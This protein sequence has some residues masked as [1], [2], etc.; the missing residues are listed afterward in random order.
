MS[1]SDKSIQLSQAWWGRINP[2]T[3]EVEKLG[4][5]DTVPTGAQINIAR[6]P[7]ADVVEFTIDTT[8]PSFEAQ[9]VLTDAGRLTLGALLSPRQHIYYFT[10]RSGR[11]S[12]HN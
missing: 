2:E 12:K 6:E 10:R 3:G 8:L 1:E 7:A 4:N 11:T 9:G 5:L